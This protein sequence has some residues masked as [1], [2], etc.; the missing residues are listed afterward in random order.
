MG[1]VCVGG[2][3]AYSYQARVRVG[4]GGSRRAIYEKSCTAEPQGE[5][6]KGCDVNKLLAKASPAGKSPFPHAV[7]PL[8]ATPTLVWRGREDKVMWGVDYTIA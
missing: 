5:P 4:V 8:S 6:G 2:H 1:V 7:A 3:F